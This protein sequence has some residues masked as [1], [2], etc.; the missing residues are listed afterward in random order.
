M[1]EGTF[2]ERKL[3]RLGTDQVLVCRHGT[4][5]PWGATGDLGT[6]FSPTP[7]RVP[8]KHCQAL[9][10]FDARVPF[11]SLTPRC[12]KYLIF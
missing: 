2:S 4:H 11:M 8:K 5:E 3:A 10:P 7:W 12:R 9:H 6:A 1:S